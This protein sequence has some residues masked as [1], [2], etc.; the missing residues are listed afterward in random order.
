MT[1]VYANGM[2]SKPA[3]TSL[4]VVTAINEILN[5]GKS[6]TIYTLDGKL[7][8]NQAT[9]LNGLKGVYIINNKT[10]VVK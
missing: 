7:I 5:S 4:E 9:S 10:V 3:T 1:A 6:F 8:S 2:E